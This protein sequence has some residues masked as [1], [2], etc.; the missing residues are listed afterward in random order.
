MKGKAASI[1]YLYY[2]TAIHSHNRYLRLFLIL[3]YTG[4]IKPTDDERGV[5]MPED[6]KRVESVILA[7][8]DSVKAIHAGESTTDFPDYD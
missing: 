3:Y 8:C 7:F 6:R 1:L 2:T 5:G 4:M